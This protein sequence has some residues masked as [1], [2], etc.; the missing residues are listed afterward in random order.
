MSECTLCEITTK[1]HDVAV[2][3]RDLERHIVARLERHV[4]RLEEALE[5][6]HTELKRGRVLLKETRE[7][8]H[9]C[10]GLE[11]EACGCEECE[12]TTDLLIA[13]DSHIE[14]TEPEKLNAS[15]RKIMRNGP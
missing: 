9:G 14:S 4:R 5:L 1:F 15:R 2:K 12:K 6:A 3:E 10:E 13:V 8:L 7:Y 11:D